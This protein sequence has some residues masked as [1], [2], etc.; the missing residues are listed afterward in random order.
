M[1]RLL[2]LALAG[3]AGAALAAP[4]VDQAHVIN[5]S[6]GGRIIYAGN[7]PAQTFTAG[8]SGV[9]S[10]VDVLLY[11]N[12]GD[13]GD[14]ALEIWP[15]VAD[16]PAG[17]TPLWSSPI[18]TNSVP[19]GS[20]DY[21]AVDVSA[22]GLFM[23][24]GEQYA[25]AVNGSAGLSDPYAVWTSGFPGYT[26]G[27][28]FSRS[29][30]WTNASGQFDYGFRTWVDPDATSGLN[31]VSL[32]LLAD[33][34]TRLYSNGAA[35]TNHSGTSIII[36]ADRTDG[37]DSR[38]LFT[39][40]GSVL[41]EGAEIQSA[42]FSFQTL[43]FTSGSAGDPEVEVYGF[44]GNGLPTAGDASD[45]SRPLGT[46]GP[47]TDT[48]IQSVTLN[49]SEI[50]SLLQESSTVG[51]T[52]Y[53]AGAPQWLSI[54]AS[55]QVP[56]IPTFYKAATLTVGLTPTPP[57]ARLPD[58]DHNGDAHVD[59]ADYT[60]WRDT[61]GEQQAYDDWA[62]NYG[63]APDAGVK[64]GGFESGDFTDWQV[65]I[66]DN[67]NVSFG[68]PRV[69]SFDVDG[70]GQPSDALRVRLGRSDT[71]EFGG[72]VAI[73][74]ELLL[75]AGD[76]EFSADVASQSLQSGGNT[77][78]GNYELSIDG[79]IV[80]QVLLNGT[81]IDGFEVLRESLFASLTNLQPGYHTIR[82]AISRGGTNS[83]EI[84]Q[85]I[86]NIQIT[87]AAPSQAVPEPTAGLMAGLL[88]ACVAAARR[89]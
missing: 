4:V 67:T 66:E 84:Y 50:Q 58:G 55:E 37:A 13:I 16:G 44:A 18:D 12:A 74:Q 61:G 81:S 79:V 46:T 43:S 87:P 52:A 22:G 40:D 82:L 8:A 36:D 51:L 39:F 71:S 30:A 56:F 10:Q 6:V 88:L 3:I 86:D 60:V 69:E 70:D 68:Y 21:V 65:V 47:V 48:G 38:G 78:P 11:R 31:E 7:A 1:L 32:P 27:D 63:T 19:T 33:A 26:S 54:T 80:D 59:A 76:Y 9:L 64:N 73:E 49:A 15:V 53:Q 57:A 20:S 34:E 35:I 29:G 89:G 77:G 85:L 62:A 25:I 17:S 42:A 5:Q 23:T 2:S 14:L 75:G 41:P 45:L 28:Q 24:P 83:R 72:T